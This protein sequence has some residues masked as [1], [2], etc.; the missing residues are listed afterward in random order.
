VDNQLLVS[1]LIQNPKAIR[2][3]VN[4][5]RALPS[6]PASPSACAVIR[7]YKTSAR[8]RWGLSRRQNGLTGVE[9]SVLATKRAR[10]GISIAAGGATQHARPV[11]Q[12][13]QPARILLDAPSADRASDCQIV[14]TVES[15]V[16][17]ICMKKGGRSRPPQVTQRGRRRD[18][19]LGCLRAVSS[20]HVACQQKG[21]PSRPSHS[22]TIRRPLDVQTYRLPV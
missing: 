22:V 6:P 17:K 19:T 12:H 15:T 20:R 2:L 11:A 18:T 5:C 1:Y 16:N 9:R 10:D 14:V 13:D 8:P 3:K 21:W 7:A 4:R